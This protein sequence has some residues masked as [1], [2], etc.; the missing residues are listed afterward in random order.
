MADTSPTSLTTVATEHLA[1]WLSHLG[2]SPLAFDDTISL[3]NPLLS[4][5]RLRARL[6]SRQSET[7]AAT[8]FV[9]QA[10]PAFK[11]LQPGQHVMVGV[12]IDGARHRRA[13]SP[14]AIAGHPG[15]FA[16]TVQRQTGGLVSNHLHEH[17]QPGGLIEVE[18]P[19]GA[20]TLPRVTPPQLLLVAGGSGITPAMAMLEHLHREARSTRVTLVYFARSRADRIFADTL[21]KLSTEWGSFRYLP[22]DS[23]AH[24]GTDA[25]LQAAPTVLDKALL[26]SILPQWPQLP[27]YCCGPA[28]LMAA[29]RTLWQ[30]AG[31]S[32]NLHLEAF[33][34]AA[35]DGDPLARHEVQYVRDAQT[36][37]FVAAGNQTLLAA[38]EQAGL[39]LKH[40]CRQGICHECTCRLHSGSVRDVQ[41]GARIDGEGQPIR[42]CV[43][44]AMS[45]LR[46]ESLN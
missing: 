14:R 38:G 40:G 19:T 37:P 28:P 17:L 34:L 20:F 31:S 42:L 46:L 3:V 33:A 1:G 27:A 15:R 25:A 44:S 12:V 29:A 41:S 10:G 18:Q 43:S 11:R 13:Y 2:V 26:D 30:E 9:L 16:I 32:A 4:V 5:H 35:P 8:T 23:L 24:T 6:V 7:P 39:S 21:A 22:V 36:K 45:D